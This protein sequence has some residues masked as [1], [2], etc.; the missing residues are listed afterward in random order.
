MEMIYRLWVKVERKEWFLKEGFFII[1][2]DILFGKLVVLK[3]D[4]KKCLIVK[5]MKD[6]VEKLKIRMIIEEREWWEKMI[7]EEEERVKLWDL[8]N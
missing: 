7:R 1:L 3:L 8:L 5:I 4:L 6:F 2:R